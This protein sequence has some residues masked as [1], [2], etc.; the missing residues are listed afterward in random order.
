[1]TSLAPTVIKELLIRAAQAFA[2]DGWRQ[3]CKMF[4]LEQRGSDLVISVLDK[5]LPK[6]VDSEKFLLKLAKAGTEKPVT[7]YKTLGVKP[8]FCGLG[9]MEEGPMTPGLSGEELASLNGVE[10]LVSRSDLRHCRLITL[11]DLDG[12][13]FNACHIQGG[14]P[15]VTLAGEAGSDV[16]AGAPAEGLRQLLIVVL[17]A[18]PAT[19]ERSEAIKTLGEMWTDTPEEA[20]NRAIHRARQK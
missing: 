9:L 7:V 17:Q 12:R 18:L 4:F 14:S 10:D 2:Q 3:P 20:V 16:V 6:H 19:Q 13:V 1:M 8:G 5:P 11:I 15:W